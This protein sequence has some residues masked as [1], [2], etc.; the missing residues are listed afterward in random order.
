M[1]AANAVGASPPTEN[2][3]RTNGVRRRPSHTSSGTAIVMS[4]PGIGPTLPPRWAVQFPGDCF[5]I[6]RIS[7]ATP[8]STNSPHRPTMMAGSRT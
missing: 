1:P 8:V 4:A 7:C 2:I 5:G 3:A 6:S